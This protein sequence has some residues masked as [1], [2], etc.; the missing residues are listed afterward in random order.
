MAAETVGTSP[1]ITAM[2]CPPLMLSDVR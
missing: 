2:K 1:R